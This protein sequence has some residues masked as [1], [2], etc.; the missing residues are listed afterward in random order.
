M[1]TVTRI[2]LNELL[3]CC[4]KV[5]RQHDRFN[6]AVR[7]IYR[8]FLMVFFF[9]LRPTRHEQILYLFNLHVHPLL[10]VP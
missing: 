10:P 7:I 6:E 4:L 5:F 8:R 1:T 2:E 9:V 3:L